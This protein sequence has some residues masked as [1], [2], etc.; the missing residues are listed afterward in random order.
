MDYGFRRNDGFWTFDEFIKLRF[1]AGNLAGMTESR[2]LQLPL[3]SQLQKSC[4]EKNLSFP[5]K[6]ESS[7]FSILQKFL[8]SR[9][10]GNDDFCNWLCCKRINESTFCFVKIN[11]RYSLRG[12]ALRIPPPIPGRIKQLPFTP[13]RIPGKP[14]HVHSSPRGVKGTSHHAPW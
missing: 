5:R 14:H 3:L 11:L 7:L 2:G 10:H 8:D 13:S 9:L 4:R 12:H 1:L 6:W